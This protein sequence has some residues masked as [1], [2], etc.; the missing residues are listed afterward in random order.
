MYRA[1]IASLGLAT[2]LVASPALATIDIHNAPGAVQP[3]ENVL[4]TDGTGHSVFGETNQTHT[5]VTFTSLANG[6]DLN[7]FASGQARVDAVGG[8][9][10][11]LTFSLTDG[12]TFDKVEFDLH[13]AMDAT[14]S[15]TVTFL[16]SFAG[17]STSETFDLGNGNNWFSAETTG[18]DRISAV[19]FDTSGLGVDDLRQ[20]RLGGI[21]T[22]AGTPIPAVPEPASW[23]MMLAG[24]SFIGFAMRSRC[25]GVFATL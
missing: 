3:E 9:L 21:L 15:V 11:T 10:D 16:G 5:G 6:V 2:F 8:P 12:G 18:G 25:K 1:Y 4:L 22:A 24:F 23:A 7:A 20:V 13:K 19:T 14:G 17:G